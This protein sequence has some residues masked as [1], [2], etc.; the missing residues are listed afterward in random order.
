[1][2]SLVTALAI[3]AA[4]LPASLQAVALAPEVAAPAGSGADTLLVEATVALARGLPWRA[5]AML[6]PLVADRGRRSPDA[7]LLAATAASR[8]R[9][10]REVTAL[11]DGEPWLDSIAGGEGRRLLARAALE[12]GNDSIAAG[13][14]AVAAG[15]GMAPG[16]RGP[17]LV[18]LAQALERLEARDSA[19]SSYLRAAPLLPEAADWLRLRA[20]GL[21]ADPALRK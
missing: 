3:G 2:I 6:A 21:T 18:V 15:G 5:S 7:V 13:H 8:W 9:G 20:A 19:A 11:L 17:A 12:L 10:W 16:V 4:A 1:M 14:A